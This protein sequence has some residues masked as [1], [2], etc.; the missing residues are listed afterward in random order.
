M[1][2]GLKSLSLGTCEITVKRC[3]QVYGNVR[4]MVLNDLLT[5]VILGQD[6]ILVDQGLH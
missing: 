3:D 6:F 2:K 5:D 1:V 4:V